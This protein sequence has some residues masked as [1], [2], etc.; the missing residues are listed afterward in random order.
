ME[1]L[2]LVD[3][4]MD[5]LPNGNLEVPNGDKIIPIANQLMDCFDEIIA[6]K[7]WH[8]ANHSSFAANHP[9]RKPFQ[10]MNLNGYEQTLWPMHCV[11]NT[12]GAE[13][14]K[15]LNQEKIDKIIY[16]GTNPDIDSYSAFYD[17]LHLKQTDLDSYL[18]SKNIKNLF[19]IGLALDYCVKYTALDAI[20]LGYQV[21]IVE[22]GCMALDNKKESMDK[23]RDE[24]KNQ[25]IKFMKSKEFEFR[26]A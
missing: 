25:G 16:K 20:G 18:K 7:D 9:W 21:T 17:N 24:L 5:F 23:L 1:A 26:L 8:P 4:Q 3:I 15:S 22:D 14:P 6:T 12:F 10:I 13:F 19:I 11:Q 2:I